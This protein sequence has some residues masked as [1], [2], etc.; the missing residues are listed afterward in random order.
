MVAVALCLASN[1]T[2]AIAGPGWV[3]WYGAFWAVCSVT[4]LVVGM[5]R[6]GP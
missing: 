1:M 5:G 2:I 4:A 6:V 3:R